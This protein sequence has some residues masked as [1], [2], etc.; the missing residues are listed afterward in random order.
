MTTAPDHVTLTQIAR[1]AWTGRAAAATWRRR[2][3]D[4]PS[5]VGGTSD[6]PLFERTAAEAWL[7]AHDRL[8]AFTTPTQDE[9]AGAR[10]TGLQL[11][12]ALV[13]GILA[14]AFVDT[15]E[16]EAPEDARAAL[17]LLRGYAEGADTL[18]EVVPLV[19]ELGYLTASGLVTVNQYDR[20]RVDAWLTA[21]T[22]TAETAARDSV[23]DI[24]ASAD[25]AA[26]D[27]AQ[28]AAEAL[29]VPDRDA[30]YEQHADRTARRLWAETHAAKDTSRV[31]YE[32]A[33]AAGWLAAH[34]LTPALGGS[35]QRIDQ[36]LE[37][38]ARQIIDQPGDR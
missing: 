28:I 2:Y 14:G 17:A 10:L 29:W 37:A 1:M 12:R 13:P 4:F 20:S 24:G 31:H 25:V 30:L 3:D 21:Q 9:R 5:S 19:L 33:L 22:Q 18:T 8:P 27:V 35:A 36:H 16:E 26:V 15:Y 38:L 6:S 11:V 7:R 32:V 23:D 34:V